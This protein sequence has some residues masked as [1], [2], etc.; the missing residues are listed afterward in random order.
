MRPAQSPSRLIATAFA[1]LAI[2]SASLAPAAV[3]ATSAGSAQIVSRP[4]PQCSS[5]E[6]LWEADVDNVYQNNTEKRVT[7]FYC[8]PSTTRAL[9]REEV[10]AAKRTIARIE[11]KVAGLHGTPLKTVVVAYY[12][13]AQR[14]AAGATSWLSRLIGR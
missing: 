8:V 10:E 12:G 9:T 3:A 4:A 1:L 13:P 7:A 14:P 6:T 11:Y 5:N 2:A